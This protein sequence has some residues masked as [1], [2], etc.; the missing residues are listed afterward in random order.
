MTP[1]TLDADVM[2]DAGK[3]RA[4]IVFRS[5][6]EA[7][8]YRAATGN[9]PE[10]E[11]WRPVPLDLPALS[12]ILE[13]HGCSHVA[14][15]EPW[16]GTG[17]VDFFAVADFIGMLEGAPP[18]SRRE[19]TG[20][21]LP[22]RGAPAFIVADRETEA[23]VTYRELDEVRAPAGLPDAGV[24]AGDPGVVVLEHEG[25]PRAIEVEYADEGGVTKAF[26]VYAPDLS[27][28]YGVHP[29]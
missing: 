13:L 25:P 15:P 6:E 23:T 22:S 17:G 10:A 2:E 8:K 5:E 7:G 26:V 28:V 14:M 12:D 21:G 27:E 1:E 3:G 11:G 18:P 9:H 4:M 24:E 20:P 16:T 29:G 19:P